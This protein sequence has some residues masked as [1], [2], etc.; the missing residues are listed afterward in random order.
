MRP[1]PACIYHLLWPVKKIFLPICAHN[2]QKIPSSGSSLRQAGLNFLVRNTANTAF[3]CRTWVCMAQDRSWRTK[4]SRRCLTR[5]SSALSSLGGLVIDGLRFEL[6]SART[7]HPS[8][9]GGGEW[10]RRGFR[11]R[12]ENPPLTWTLLVDAGAQAK[13]SSNCVKA[14][15]RG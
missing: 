14:V 2:F 4:S 8:I 15:S 9:M 13:F 1:V 7:A 11:R 6:R 10:R 3:N 5:S 12:I